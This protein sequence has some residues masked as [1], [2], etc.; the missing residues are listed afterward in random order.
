MSQ[1]T[2]IF[3]H[4]TKTAGGTLKLALADAFG[5]D[6]EMLYGPADLERLKEANLSKTKMIYG[7]TTFGVHERLGFTKTP[8][9]YCFMRHPV[10]RTISHYYHLRDVEKGPVGDKIRASEDIN[11]F[12]ANMQHWEFSNFMVKVL[13]GFVKQTPGKAANTPLEEAKHKNFMAKLLSGFAKTS[14][15]TAERTSLEEAKHNLDTYFDFVGFQEYFPLSMVKLEKQLGREIPIENS[16]N[17]GRY[18]LEGISN[19]TLKNIIEINKAD[20][21]LYKYA[22]QKF[23]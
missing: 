21:E 20:L 2:K 16:I 4:L 13:S 22:L 18:T 23:L 8:R 1:N 19:K 12:F 17:I 6:V 9:H 3:L 11:D 7:H 10:T 5:S 14:P 15:S